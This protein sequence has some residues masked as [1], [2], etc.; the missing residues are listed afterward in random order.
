MTN[1]IQPLPAL[2]LGVYDD[3]EMNKYIPA[4]LQNIAEIQYAIILYFTILIFEERALSISIPI[5]LSL[6]PNGVLYN[7]I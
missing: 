5:D 4:R 3:I 1:A 6:R 7:K 2:M